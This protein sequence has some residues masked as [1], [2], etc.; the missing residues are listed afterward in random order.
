MEKASFTPAK[1]AAGETMASFW[2]GSPM[3][4]GPPMAMGGRGR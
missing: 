3:F 2:M 1:D 4:L